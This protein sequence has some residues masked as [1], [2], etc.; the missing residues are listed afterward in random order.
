MANGASFTI[1]VLRRPDDFAADLHAP[2]EIHGVA[3]LRLRGIGNTVREAV[4]ICLTELESKA[5]DG[6]ENAL[7]FV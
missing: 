1:T 3:D 2:S 6:D 7:R 4:E 5:A